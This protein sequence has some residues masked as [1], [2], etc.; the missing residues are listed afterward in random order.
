[1]KKIRVANKQ[2]GEYLMNVNVNKMLDARWLACPMPIGNTKKEMANLEPG[3]VNEIQ[4]IVKGS[5][6]DM[7]AWAL[8][9]RNQYLGTI[10][11][12]G[13]LKHYLRKASEKE[14]RTEVIH[15]DVVALEG[16]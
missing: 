16:L 1:V 13:T 14:E 4:E 10:E 7:K 12:G 8:S 15:H 3:Q 6:V 5:T 2:E 9:N 11:E